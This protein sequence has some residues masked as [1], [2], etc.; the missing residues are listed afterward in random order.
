MD[1][2][3]FRVF[4]SKVLL[5]T[6]FNNFKVDGY[7]ICNFY[8][9][10]LDVLCR[11][12]RSD[13]LLDRIK[14]HKLNRESF[15]HRLQFDNQAMA[16]FI[17]F[18]VTCPTSI[19]N[20]ECRDN[21]F[22]EYLEEF[23]DELMNYISI[24]Y[25]Q[26]KSDRHL[27]LNLNFDL[28]KSLIKPVKG[29]N[30]FRECLFLCSNQ[31]LIRYIIDTDI[32][33]LENYKYIPY[34][35]GVAYKEFAEY[36]I[37]TNTFS[38]LVN[39]IFDTH[40]LFQLARKGN[41]ELLKFLML[42]R[43]NLRFLVVGNNNYYKVGY[44]INISN[45]KATK[46]LLST[47]Y[48]LGKNE[49]CYTYQLY[50]SG[51]NKKAEKLE[52]LYPSQLK[53]ASNDLWLVTSQNYLNTMDQFQYFIKR[54][55][56]FGYSIT[57][58]YKFIHNL[59]NLECLQYLVEKELAVNCK[60]IVDSPY[61]VMYYYFGLPVTKSFL[62]TFGDSPTL[63][64][65]GDLRIAELLVNLIKNHDHPHFAKIQLKKS[66]ILNALS[67]GYTEFV[68]Y[69][70]VFL[71]SVMDRIIYGI[72]NTDLLNLKSSKSKLYL[73]PLL[74]PTFNIFLPN[75]SLSEFQLETHLLEAIKD[76]DI[77]LMNAYRILIYQGTPMMSI[78]TH[79]R[80]HTIGRNASPEMLNL[81]THWNL[82]NRKSTVSRLMK[83]A[84]SG[85]NL[86]LL[87]YLFDEY[88]SIIFKKSVQSNLLNITDIYTMYE[89]GHHKLMWYLETMI[90]PLV[91]HNPIF[92][93]LRDKQ[94]R[95]PEMFSIINV[96]LPNIINYL[97]SK[98]DNTQKT[99]SFYYLVN[100]SLK[101]MVLLYIKYFEKI[102]FQ[103]NLNILYL[104]NNTKKFARKSSCY[105]RSL[106]KKYQDYFEKIGFLNLNQ[107][108]LQTS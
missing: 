52:K 29:L 21:L 42:D 88:P 57:E 93:F 61:H 15:D 97:F 70:I 98:L 94:V 56:Q 37:K 102:K 19:M 58:Y 62:F 108:D 75:Y 1:D 107:I 83:Y 2:L 77:S 14:M 86:R 69:L 65:H 79:N 41:L 99:I 4:R 60:N 43:S 45:Y 5:I 63:G 53:F 47:D 38:F 16:A 100:K 89:S 81:V 49:Y 96:H 103:P 28:I 68:Q 92:K 71:P 22:I 85:S 48:L 25:N 30:S 24:I 64:F 26:K 18:L 50:C 46:F 74:P 34:H 39:N 55:Q 82:S 23:R 13:I 67:L 59:N 76:N 31:K 33:W 105:L 8:Q 27:I 35:N 78:I 32:K 91:L 72:K 54:H 44:D 66:H 95:G 12:N 17:K 80:F 51:H 104:Y 36:C 20:E 9:I 84:I 7:S 106:D 90:H 87:L 101:K 73:I 11:N 3:F 10:P 40:T 6:I